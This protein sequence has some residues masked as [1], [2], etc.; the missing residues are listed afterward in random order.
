VLALAE[1]SSGTADTPPYSAYAA[2]FGSFTGG[3]AL[4]V[5]IAHL[6]GRDPREH[7]WL[8]FVVRSAASFKAARTIAPRFGRR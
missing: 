4:A 3:L 6:L 2:I 5:G 1:S 8:D 7:T